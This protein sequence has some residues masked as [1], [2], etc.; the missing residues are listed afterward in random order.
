MRREWMLPVLVAAMVSGCGSRES[1]E[2]SETKGNNQAPG[3]AAKAERTPFV[4]REA[5]VRFD[6]PPQWDLSLVRMETQG[7]SAADS[8]LPGAA[9]AVTFSYRAEQP[10][11]RPEVLLRL[12]VFEKD[13]WARIA[14]A[15]GPPAGAPI[16]SVDAWVFVASL[17]QSNP[18]REGLL[19]ADQF[20]AMTLTLADVREHFSIERGGPVD[21]AM[22]G[23]SAG[24]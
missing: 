13:A 12:M 15:P 24:K 7:G 1:R 21:M 19:D 22:R 23:G 3:A 4:A 16:D 11:H 18:Y 6:P 8:V 20:E 5:G 9:Y 14:A 10:A 17:P 2:V